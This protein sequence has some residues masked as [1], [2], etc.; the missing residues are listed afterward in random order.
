MFYQGGASPPQENLPILQPEVTAR[1][2]RRRGQQSEANEQSVGDEL[3]SADLSGE[4][5]PALGPLTRGMEWQS[6]DLR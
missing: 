2:A 4:P 1:V 6:P 3:D 5:E